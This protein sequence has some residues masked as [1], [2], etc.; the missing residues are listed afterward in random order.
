M[1]F[2]IIL[3][4]RCNRALGVN[5]RFKSTKCP[6]CNRKV[7]FF[8]DNIEYS[9]DSEKDLALKISKINEQIFEEVEVDLDLKTKNQKGTLR[10]LSSE[11]A[12]KKAEPQIYENLDPFKRIALKYKDENES[13]LLIEKLIKALGQ[14]LGEITLEN[15]QKLLT[16]CNLNQDK[17]IEYLD[18]MKTQG[19]IFEPK[20]GIYKL[21][22]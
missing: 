3:C 10:N 19:I 1:K 16:E 11:V 8:K 17:V 15:F 22:E 18:Q 9:T 7:K 13:I 20:I 2:G 4:K 12:A 5:L 14:E 6:F 21:I